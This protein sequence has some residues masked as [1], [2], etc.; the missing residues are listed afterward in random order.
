[1]PVH[2]PSTRAGE[3]VEHFNAAFQRHFPEDSSKLIFGKLL[4]E[5]ALCLECIFSDKPKPIFL[6]AAVEFP[7]DKIND[8]SLA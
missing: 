3:F 8:S 6:A 2:R 5:C 1:V 7:S 4:Y